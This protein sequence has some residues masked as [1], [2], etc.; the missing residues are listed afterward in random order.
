MAVNANRLK[1]YGKDQD[2]AIAMR[3]LVSTEWEV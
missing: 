3:N 2:Y 1:G